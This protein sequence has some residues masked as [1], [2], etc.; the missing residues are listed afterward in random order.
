[1]MGL[2]AEAII[3][4]ITASVSKIQMPRMGVGIER[5]SVMVKE[6]VSNREQR[7]RHL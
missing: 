2:D 7:V 3:R 4:I 5:T 6:D 1:M